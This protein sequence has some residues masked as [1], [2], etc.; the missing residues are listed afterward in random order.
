MTNRK[1][2]ALVSSLAFAA[3][4]AACFLWPRLRIAGYEALVQV[5]PAGLR[6]WA[7]D[8][9]GS[10]GDPGAEALGRIVADPRADIGD[11]RAALAVLGEMAEEGAASLPALAG[12]LREQDR[13]LRLEVVTALGEMG[14]PAQQSLLRV[15]DQDEDDQVRI[16]ALVSLTNQGPAAAPLVLEVFEH[17]F[18][19]GGMFD[20]F[21]VRALKSMG[22]PAV[23]LL[24]AALRNQD[25]KIRR[26]AVVALGLTGPESSWALSEL[27][28]LAKDEDAE[29]REALAEALV[30]L[31]AP[32]T[33]AV[34]ALI[35]ILN[36]EDEVEDRLAAA[37]ALGSY[38]P[39]AASAV[40][41]LIRALQG[42][43][44]A[45]FYS[46]ARIRYI[47]SLGLIGPGAAP[48]APVLREIAEADHLSVAR[49]AEEAL[50]AIDPRSK[51][52]AAAWI[53]GR[54]GSSAKPYRRDA[55][56]RLVELAPDS[57]P[58][59]EQGLPSASVLE[60][61]VAALALRQLGRLDPEAL[62]ALGE[63]AYVR[64]VMNEIR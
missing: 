3:L 36:T 46:R 48:A 56:R 24:I 11:R 54:L 45:A 8:R 20:V 64:G 60:R 19:G 7:F 40:P 1:R 18:S 2:F 6:L 58:A 43:G 26:D 44:E 25:A 30:A 55:V 31:E 34:P 13:A 21:L 62:K 17:R 22:R 52:E 14:L 16:E 50:C 32:P 33:R 49:A 63:D 35:G 59:L 27:I 57:L 37:R 42:E 61:A 28:A 12:A 39:A 15:L 4:L 47:R 51:T 53:L 38:G 23:E 5:G 41:G 9:I 29:V 10:L